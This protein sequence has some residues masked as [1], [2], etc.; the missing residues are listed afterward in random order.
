MEIG[1]EIDLRW[2]LVRS[3]IP[4]RIRFPDDPVTPV[5]HGTA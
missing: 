2:S 4:V 1:Y 3:R 5:S